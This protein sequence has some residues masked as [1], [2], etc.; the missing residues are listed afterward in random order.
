M[1]DSER[2]NEDIL[3]EIQELEDK[4]CEAEPSEQEGLQGRIDQLKDKL[5]E[6]NIPL[7]KSIA[8]DFTHSGLDFEDL[9]QAGY[10]GLLNAVENYDLKR[11]TKFSTYATHLIKGEIRHQVRDNQPSVHIPQWIKRLNKKV[12]KA[13]EK[14]YQETGEYPGIKE[15]AEELNIEEEGVKEVLK[16]RDSMTYV[17]IDRERRESDPRP[18]YIDYEKIKSKH[19]ENLPLE[20]KVRIADAIEKLTEVQQQ[21]VKGIFYEDQTQEEIGEEIGTSQRQVSRIKYRVLDELESQLK[22]ES[23][24]EGEDAD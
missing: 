7:V 4:Q 12:K 14:I 5:I 6:Q 10:I 13:Q 17:S 2:S 9:R 24:D 22:D 23:D 19:E 18:E 16:A 20:F 3:E 1:K 15:L 11:G 8:G 21:V